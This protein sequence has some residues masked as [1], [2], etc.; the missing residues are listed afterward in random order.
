[1]L[2]LRETEAT[3]AARWRAGAYTGRW[4]RTVAGEDIAVLFPGRPGGP[5]G[6]DFRDAVLLRRDGSRLHGDVELHLRARSWH[7]HGHDRD[8]RYDGVVLHVV[9]QAEGTSATPLASGRWVAVAELEPAPAAAASPLAPPLEPPDGVP[10]RWPCAQLAQRLPAPALRALLDAAGDARFERRVGD[11]L[12]RLRAADGGPG[13]PHAPHDQPHPSDAAPAGVPDTGAAA[14]HGGAWQ[15]ADRVLF[16]ALAEGLAYGRERERLRH[17]GEWLA[18]GGAPDALL[19]ELPRLPRLDAARLEGLLALH[20]RW[21]AGGPWAA[22]RATLAPGAPTQARAAVVAALV[23]SG[24]AISP[25]RGAILAANVVLPFAAAWAVAH[26][27]PA[28]GACARASYAALP[29]LPP[30]QITREMVR[31]LGLRRQPAGARAQQGLQHLWALHCRAK[32]CEEC[33]C[34]L[35]SGVPMARPRPP[36]AYTA[37]HE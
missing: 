33:P 28:L 4:L 2:M 36:I 16:T 35:T 12:A 19:R 7:A 15:G 3:L 30:N 17:A 21:E 5:A 25:A 1:M 34:C 29:G 37:R 13:A 22:L 26:D 23:V 31:Q 9:R 8:A 11:L 14:D 20:A 18:S 24:G 6:P 27:D 10:S 32:R